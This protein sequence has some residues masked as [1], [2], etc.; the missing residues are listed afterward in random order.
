MSASKPPKKKLP[1]NITE[2]PD[3]EVARHL[4][5]KRAAKALDKITNP[6][7]PKPKHPVKR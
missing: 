2:M 1:A 7:E 4:F 3:L 6:P 5:G